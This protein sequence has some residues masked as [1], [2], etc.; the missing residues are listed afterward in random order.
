MGGKK[1]KKAQKG[2][3]NRGG[4]GAAVQVCP[5]ITDSLLEFQSPAISAKGSSSPKGGGEKLKRGI[6]ELFS[7][8]FS[9]ISSEQAR[10]LFDFAHHLH[11]GEHSLFLVCLL[12]VGCLLCK[13]VWGGQSS[14]L[15]GPPTLSLPPVGPARFPA[16]APEPSSSILH[17]ITGRRPP[18]TYVKLYSMSD[19]RSF[20]QQ[21]ATDKGIQNC[22]DIQLFCLGDAAVFGGR[23]TDKRSHPRASTTPTAPLISDTR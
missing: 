22:D 19:R 23:G 4:P 5:L 16:G 11:L 7:F 10:P 13:N 9:F 18:S 20:L 1:N 15:P 21:P 3:A 17:F 6:S 14:V 12:F 2:K 8:S